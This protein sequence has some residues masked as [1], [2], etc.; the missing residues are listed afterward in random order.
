MSIY[1]LFVVYLISTQDHSLFVPATPEIKG[2]AGPILL[3][4]QCWL[5]SSQLLPS[6]P[7]RRLVCV[8][9]YFCI[10]NKCFYYILLAAIYSY[11]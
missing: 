8:V 11:I 9:D 2:V 5:L 6:L 7:L 1:T 3:D 10:V 4:L